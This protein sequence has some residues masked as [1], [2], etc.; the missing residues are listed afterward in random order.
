[1]G[2]GARAGGL[3]GGV[4]S[5]SAV[6]PD[7]TTVAAL[8]AVNAVGSPVDLATGELYAVRLGLGGEFSG[9]GAPLAAEAAAHREWLA[10]EMARAQAQVQPGSAT[11]IGVVATDAA[12]SKAQCQKL[13][14]VGQGGIDRAVLPSHSL[15]DGD[16]LFAMATCARPT[17]EVLGLVAL[18]DAAAGCVARA[19]GHA[20]LA[21]VPVSTPAVE[22]VTYRDALPSAFSSAP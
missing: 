8:V 21:A 7:G 19:V 18:M 4:G 5:A 9:V 13:A 14:G 6:L 10:V 17:P 3:K 22:L 20:M 1:V 2:T 15:L 11:V 16:T 12:L